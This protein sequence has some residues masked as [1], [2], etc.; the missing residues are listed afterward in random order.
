MAAKKI[1]KKPSVK[2]KNLKVE[3][4]GSGWKGS[5]SVPANATSTTKN[6]RY[7]ALV[8][9]WKLVRD[10]KDIVDKHKEKDET[11]S[12][13][14]QSWD[15]FGKK[16]AK[17]YPHTK[18]NVQA[19]KLEVWGKNDKG[20]G[21]SVTGVYNYTTPAKPTVKLEY[22]S[23]TG[24]VTATVEVDDKS[25]NAERA[26]TVYELT[27][28]PSWK[29]GP[30]AAKGSFG[31]NAKKA[32]V[33][34][35]TGSVIDASFGAGKYITYELTAHSRGLAGDSKKATAKLVVGMPV[36][37]TI[38]SVKASSMSPTGV[39][40]VAVSPGALTASIQLERRHG[41][42][43]SWETVNGATDNGTMGYLYDQIQAANPT[44]GEY[45]WYRVKSSRDNFSTYSQ[46][47]RADS[48][49]SSQSPAAGA[50][51]D[52][53][54]FE[55]GDDGQSAK[56]V[57]GW[58]DG[59]APSTG[60]LV[61]WSADPHA[62][63]STAQPNDYD[64]EWEDASSQAPGEWAK[65]QT[66]YVADIDEGVP[67]YARVRRYTDPEEGAR[68]FSAWSS[69]A[70][71]TPVT[72]PSA[73][74]LSAPAYV[75]RGSEIPVSWTYDGGAAQAEWALHPAG[76][77]S[78]SLGG[79]DDALGYATI[80]A[81]AYGDS[82]ELSFY[83]SVST[84]GD[85]CDSN[86]VRVGIVD[87]PECSVSAP[88]TLS[89]QPLSFGVTCD[90]EDCALVCKVISHGIAG[91]LNGDVVWAD[92]V[93]PQWSA[94]SRGFAATVEVPGAIPLVDTGSYDVTVTAVDGE[95][96]LRSEEASGTFGVAW[97]HQAPEPPSTILVTPDPPSLAVAI[98]LS[99]PAGAA[100]GDVY[101]VYRCTPE[102]EDLIGEGLALDATAVDSYAPFSS[103]ADLRYRI[104]CRTADGD[105]AEAA[106]YYELPADTV[107][108]DWA[109]GT[110][111]LPW[112]VTAR[113]SSA[114]SFERR[115][116]LD[117]GDPTGHWNGS[118][119]RDG[120]FTSQVPYVA[121]HDMVEAVMALAAHA[122]PCFCRFGDGKAYAC[123]VDVDYDTAHDS[124]LANVS[125]TAK[126][127]ALADPFRLTVGGE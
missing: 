30:A 52:I 36:A 19:V 96:G 34:R 94:S 42:T 51:C 12:S 83:A 56:L 110:V 127:C 120:G 39:I 20:A 53:V 6:D 38:K 85:Y 92:V 68:A 125:L 98:A 15:D 8:V 89:A 9:K 104:V 10:G 74:V 66:I 124:A 91:Q 109:G 59:D 126:R 23:Q 69:V 100:D 31:S 82:D 122:G 123:N 22:N 75:E 1:E 60:T 63:E 76:N 17:Y 37:S 58:T 78:G 105:E 71:T 62:W 103:V 107:R 4:N 77:P 55:P 102:G 93:E 67:V 84:G 106:Y 26:D 50:E 61:T 95:T 13:D 49:F 57:V 29:A 65:T 3:K 2:V 81:A 70:V 116:H 88:A 90:S 101:D 25:E 14:T 47:F 80:P 54:S 33:T 121:D 108:I 48:M 118:V 87:A 99:A 41:S 117:G 24:V 28:K 16:R 32:T 5:W 73:V 18:V 43:G 111:D 114:K 35:D 97:A 40:T 7:T 113:A 72:K 119:E 64:A 21:P 79:G 112:N 44:V 46:P 45:L 86:T 11:T 115:P 27:V